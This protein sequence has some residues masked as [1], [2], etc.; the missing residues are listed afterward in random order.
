MSYKYN[1]YLTTV[2]YTELHFPESILVPSVA[3]A[4]TGF[5]T[6]KFFKFTR[7]EDALFWI[8]PSQIVFV[9]KVK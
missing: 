4:Q 6:N 2:M 7:G 9:K 8:P 5:W 1:A 3:D